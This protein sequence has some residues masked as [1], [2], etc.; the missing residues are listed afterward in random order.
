MQHQGL[1]T[2]MWLGLMQ[3]ITIANVATAIWAVARQYLKLL[4]IWPRETSLITMLIT[5][6]YDVKMQANALLKYLRTPSK[7]YCKGRA[8]KPL[9]VLMMIGP[10]Y[11]Q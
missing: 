2:V 1:I 11:F 5:A 8:D 3:V 4:V 6:M 10:K 9:Q 7:N